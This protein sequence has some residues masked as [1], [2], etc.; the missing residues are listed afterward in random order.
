VSARTLSFLKDLLRPLKRAIFPTAPKY[1]AKITLTLGKQKLHFEAN[2][3]TERW[4]VQ[5]H[6]Q[7]PEM[8]SNLLASIAPTDV[9]Y[10]IGSNVGLVTVHCAAVATHGLV[11]SFEPDPE[12]MKRLRRNVAMNGFK[13]VWF[14]QSALSDK[15]GEATL[16]T[17]GSAGASP[18]LR[19]Q[20]GRTLAPKGRITINTETIDYLIG[21]QGL[22][23]PDVMKIDVEGAEMLVLCG[24]RQLLAGGFTKR[25][26]AIFV[27]VHPQFLPQFDSSPEALRKFMLDRRYD[28]VE[29]KVRAE[30]VHEIYRPLT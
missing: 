12:N 15:R 19:E 9:I 13:N 11:C 2:N 6:G 22:S 27:E 28:C 1:P 20:P 3:N 24:A 10:D 7:E 5:D 26:K 21:E 18:T 8:L 30:Q 4:R 29:S 14:L 16:H 25:P 23:P 17:D